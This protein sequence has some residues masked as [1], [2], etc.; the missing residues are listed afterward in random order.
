MRRCTFLRRAAMATA[1]SFGATRF[2]TL[3]FA[4]SDL[5]R[6][7]YLTINVLGGLK[8]VGLNFLTLMTEVWG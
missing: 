2:P 1:F 7:D 3:A 6:S 8:I 4:E 5:R